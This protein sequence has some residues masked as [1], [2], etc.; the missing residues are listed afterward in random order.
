MPSRIV[1]VGLQMSANPDARCV[2]RE[3]DGAV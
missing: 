3:A 1:E 2:A